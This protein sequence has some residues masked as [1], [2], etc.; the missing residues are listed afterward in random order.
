[1]YINVINVKCKKLSEIKPNFCLTCVI[2]FL[3]TITTIEQAP[4]QWLKDLLHAGDPGFDSR[5]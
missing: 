5:R 2:G 1:M 4:M 3:M